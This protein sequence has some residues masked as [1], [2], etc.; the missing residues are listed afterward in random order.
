MDNYLKIAGLGAILMVATA[1]TSHYTLTNVSRTRIVVD[2]RYDRQPDAK[3]TAFLAPYKHQVDSVMGPVMGT[4]AHNM[5][6]KRP[7]SDLS[8]LLADIL[9]W[10]A[11]DYNEK[12]V[13]GIYNMG[14][15]RAALTKGEVTYGD[16]LAIA[17]FENKIAFTTL[18]GTKLLE[19]FS[20]IA[21]RG[22]EGV[23]RGTELVISQDG[24]L[25]SARLH[26][27]E[28]DPQGAYRVTTIDYLLGGNDGMP[29]LN[30]GTNVVSPQEERNNTRFIIMDY[31]KEQAAQGK[32]V[33]AEVEGRIRVKN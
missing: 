30:E 1:C 12:P 9:V 32:A 25:V 31:F 16:V 26:G 24:K 28:I 4:V 29:A 18:S 8:N 13:L 7:E 14:G 15:I 5:E 22:G 23:S 11:K 17:P 6:A 20:Q 33:S 27:Q 3:A 21:R 2:N 10:A 19:L